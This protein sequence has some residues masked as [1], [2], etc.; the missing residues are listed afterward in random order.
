[1]TDTITKTKRWTKRPDGSNW[2][3]FGEDDQVGRLNIITPEMRKGGVDEVKEGL[4]F[5]LSLPLD[6]PGGE[7]EESPR[8]APV[9]FARDMG[10]AG[11]LYNFPF[12]RLICS[13]DNVVMSLQYSTQWDSLAHIGAY[14]DVDGSGE[15]IPVY[16]NGWRAHEHIVGPKDG[17]PPCAHCLGIENMAM[18]GVQGRGVLFDFVRAFGTGRT[19]V[20]YDR[21]MRV[22]D[23]QK[24]EV[25]KGDFALFYTGYG[26]V[27]MSMKKQPDNA[28]LDQTGAALDGSDK[29]L[30]QW[31]DDAGL[32]SL[33]SDNPAVEYM[34][35]ALGI[36]S[37]DLLPLHEHC[38]FK[39]GI[40][41][42]EYF[43]LS[44]LANWLRGAERS[45]FQFTGPPLRL[46]GAVGSPATP[47]AAV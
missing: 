35:P 29:R 17:Q 11:P 13:D 1:L 7:P 14:F 28:V 37:H 38:I 32:V 42:G 43:W 25:R 26:D 4:C 24:I 46:P 12:G 20:D 40:H 27:L 31:I 36:D 47:V 39:L 10:P 41:L 18:T 3:E 33:I 19:L 15:K 16:Y 9:I 5:V 34:D 44:D 2:G 22:I 30:L 21:M 8:R 45:A 23:D 6:Y